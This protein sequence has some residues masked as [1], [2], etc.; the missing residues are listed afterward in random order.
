MQ[1][2]AETKLYGSTPMFKTGPGHPNIIGVNCCEH[3][4]S[5]EGGVNRDL[6]RF[7]VAD[8][9]HQNLVRVVAQDRT[10]AARKRQP[11]FSFTG[12]WVIPLIWYSTGSSIVMILSSSFLISLSAAYSVVVLPEPVGPVT[13]TIP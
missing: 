1:F 2:S 6:R 9:A 7:L 5:G 4:V 13:S 11:F 3:Q 10:Q 8:L 12:I